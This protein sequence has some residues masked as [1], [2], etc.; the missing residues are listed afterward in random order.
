MREN[1]LWKNFQEIGALTGYRLRFSNHIKKLADN[2]LVHDR[3]LPPLS[4]TNETEM[5]H[6]STN[7]NIACAYNVLF[8]QLYVWYHARHVRLDLVAFSNASLLRVVS[9]RDICIIHSYAK[10]FEHLF[11]IHSESF[12]S[13]SQRT[14]FLTERVQVMK[15]KLQCLS[16]CY[17][18]LDRTEKCITP[19][20][21][22][23]ISK[24]NN[25]L[26]Y[27]AIIK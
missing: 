10:Q 26:S 11:S 19:Q 25:L 16:W 6:L 13:Y 8:L 3:V 22:K 20:Q 15:E 27:N 5:V 2:F 4:S 17:I 12:S 1:L 9:R 7:V 18:R 24:S 21:N 23:I 14:S